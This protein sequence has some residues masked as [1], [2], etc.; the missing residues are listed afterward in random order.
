M[1]KSYG[2]A[3][4]ETDWHKRWLSGDQNRPWQVHDME[5]VN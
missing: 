4:A 5:A 1:A 3:E 2:K